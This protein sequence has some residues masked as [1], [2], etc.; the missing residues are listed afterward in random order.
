MTTTCIHCAKYSVWTLPVCLL[1]PLSSHPCCHLPP[2]HLA[3][4]TNLP[5]SVGL[6]STTTMHSAQC[7]CGLPARTLAMHAS[8][9]HWSASCNLEEHASFIAHRIGVNVTYLGENTNMLKLPEHWKLHLLFLFILLDM[10]RTLQN[11]PHPRILLFQ[12]SLES[13]L[14][15]LV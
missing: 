8:M 14:L 7:G 4:L 15:I 5:I 2:T 13:G 11:K 12:N 10:H 6:S 9:C 3:S 1:V